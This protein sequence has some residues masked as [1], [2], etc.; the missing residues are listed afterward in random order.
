MIAGCGANVTTGDG[1]SPSAGDGGTTTSTKTYSNPQYDFSIT[2][3]DR[4]TQGK[5]INGTG[6]GGSSHWTSSS[7]TTAGPSSR[8]A[9]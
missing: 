6:A 7:P 8:T 3:A 2:Y 4:F 9:M 1:S 5:P